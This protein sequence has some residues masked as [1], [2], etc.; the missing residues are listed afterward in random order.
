MEN[1]PIVD[2]IYEALTRDRLRV[3]SQPIIELSSGRI[4]SE[5]LLVRL[6]SSDRGLLC[7]DAFLPVAEEHGLA[8][9]I[10]RFMIDR[11]AAFASDG[12]RVH[13]NLSATTLCD[14]FLFDDV[15]AAVDRHGAQPGDI[16]FEI[17]ETAIPD[18]MAQV[19]ELARRMHARGFHVALDDFG[20][21]W[22][23]LR[24]LKV[25]PVSH[26]KIDREFI[27][28]IC[29]SPRASGLVEGIV[30]LAR[31]LGLRTT[32]EGVEDRQTLSALKALGVDY[33][34]GFHIGRPLAV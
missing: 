10:D 23:A 5:E 13:V 28:D 26:I 24:Y 18:D 20:S 29:W 19:G 30:A 3:V 4:V 25:L 22:G 17:T 33:A 34:Q 2:L 8:T 32:A 31:A 14:E 27:R 21:G 11:A 6:A 15:V 12:R 7:P 1:P 16:T 9:G